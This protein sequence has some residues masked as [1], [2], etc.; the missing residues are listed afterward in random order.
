[1]KVEAALLWGV[2]EE[3]SVEEVELDPPRENEV[4]VRLA[5]AGL[6]HSDAHI[7]AGE[8]PVPFPV[9]GGHEGAGVVEEVGSGVS[10]VAPG[11][12]VVLSFI[13]SCGRCR[14]C[15]TGHTYLCDLGANL[16]LG[17]QLDGT[18]RFHTRGQNVGQACLLGTFSPLTVVPMASV[19]KIDRDLP[20]DKAALLGCGVT[21]GFGS[22]VYTADVRPGDAVAVL[23]VGG[24]G[25]NA[26]QGARI[27]GA[28]LIVA[29]DPVEFKREK[30]LEFGATHATETA[31]QARELLADLTRGAMAG[32]AIIAT[33]VVEPAY[34]AQALSLVGKKG[35]VVVT[36]IAHPTETQANMSLFEMTLYEKE[37]RGSLFG[38]ANP[39]VEIPRLLTLYRKGDL[40]LDELITNTYPI[41]DVNIGFRDM[42]EGR[43]IRGLVL[44]G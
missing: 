17:P 42:T 6:C 39:Q 15:I 24:V 23:G 20:L 25:A 1:M 26:V 18:Y 21:T 29:V 3:W 30:A 40:K 16:F 13:P 19:V 2:K 32:K 9:V 31:E 4:L 5:A 33:D 7:V 10:G 41:A 27:A 35:R 34:V 38:S 36:G 37:L 11:D 8:M 22:A 14:W 43:N 44:H 28:E 12:H